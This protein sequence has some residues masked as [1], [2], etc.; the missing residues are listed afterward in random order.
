M[1]LLRK[2][3]AKSRHEHMEEKLSAYLDG[4]LSPSE[5]SAVESHLGTCGQCQWSLQ[6]LRTTVQW[7]RDLPVVPVPRVFTIPV[8]VQLAPEPRWRWS[9]PLLQGAT[10]LV[11][12]LFVF[13]VA[14]DLMMRGALPAL[15]PRPEVALMP[16][17]ASDEASEAA[18]V[19]PQ[20][21]APPAPES[22]VLVESAVSEESPAALPL[23]VPAV[24]L[25]L[26]AEAEKV[27]A[28]GALESKALGTSGFEAPAE[29]STEETTEPV[30]EA[31]DSEE[32]PATEESE[33]TSDEEKSE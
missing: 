25:E 13:A 21:E 20:A 14:G 32:A 19:R 15:A 16:A 28:T 2:G 24:E 5:R 29:E 27:V 10:A 6:T 7:T 11:A 31:S 17:P 12:L 3:S 22:T 9:M 30:A 33:D 26:E 18:E 1:G 4:Q 8:P 23:A